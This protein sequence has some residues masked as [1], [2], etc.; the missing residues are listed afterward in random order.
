MAAEYE[1]RYSL[2]AHPAAIRFLA[3]L[4]QGRFGSY[5]AA[6]SVPGADISQTREYRHRYGFGLNWE[7]EITKSIGVFSRAGWNDGHNE[8]WMFTDINH[9]ASLGISIKGRRLASQRRHGWRGR[10]DERHIAR[11]PGVPGGGWHRR[12]R[13]RWRPELRLGESFRNILRLQTFEEPPCCIGLPVRRGPGVQSRPRL[14]LDFRDA[15]ALGV[16]DAKSV[17]GCQGAWRA[18]R[19]ARTLP[20]PFRS[21]SILAVISF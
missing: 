7:Q 13:R 16:V 8:A 9:S 15:I 2:N 11:E 12:P 14:D 5:E 19:D 6:L 20:R 10:C 3:Y 17:L 1:R 4:N 21:H 18:T